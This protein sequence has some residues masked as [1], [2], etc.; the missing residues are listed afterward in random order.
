MTTATPETGTAVVEWLELDFEESVPC[1][2]YWI[3]NKTGEI[4]KRCQNPA[5]VR[6]T[7]DCPVHG[8][9]EP[10]FLCRPCLKTLEAGRVLC[11]NLR[12]TVPLI[13]TGM[14]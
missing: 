12:C 2:S 11:P 9:I 8:T 6:V 10:T 3:N 7:A 13:L 4:I 1:G 14:L 5:E